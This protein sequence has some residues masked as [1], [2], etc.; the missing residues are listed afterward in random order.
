MK[1]PKHLLLWLSCAALW[2]ATANINPTLYLDNIKFLAS[3]E[4]RGR[5]TGSPELEK[6][7]DYIARKFRDFGLQPVGGKSYYQAFEVTTSAALG[8]ANRF[9]VVS[10]HRATTLRF[11]EDYTPLHFSSAAKLNAPLVFAGY[12][13]TAPDLK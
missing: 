4:L 13:I 10:H 9:R 12:G 8:K 5:A 11:P 7:A 3:P 2:G 1:I 6:A